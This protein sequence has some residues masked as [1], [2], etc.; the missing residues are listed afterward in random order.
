MNCGDMRHTP[1]SDASLF[2]GQRELARSKLPPARR[3]APQRPLWELW[4][5]TLGARTER[6]RRKVWWGAKTERMNSHFPLGCSCFCMFVCLF[7]V[8]LMYTVFC[9]L[10]SYHSALVIILF[11]WLAECMDGKVELYV[12]VCVGGVCVVCMHAGVVLLRGL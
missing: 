6:Q 7:Y 10:F 9:F 3:L 11:E 2:S 8:F 4:L 12:C 1:F 5:M